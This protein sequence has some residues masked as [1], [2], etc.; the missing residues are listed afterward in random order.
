MRKSI[1]ATRALSFFLTLLVFTTTASSESGYKAWLRYQPVQNKV[2]ADTYRIYC[3]TVFIA[4]ESEILSSSF[5][6][7]K[8]GLK[9]MLGTEPGLSSNGEKSG[10]LIGTIDKIPPS[11]YRF[12]ETETRRMSVEGFIIKNTGK[13]I[14]ITAKSDKGILYGVFRLLMMMQYG[15]ALSDA[16]ILEN[17]KI[18]LR[19]LNH[20]DNP[21]KVPPGT[22][23]VERGYAGGSIFKWDELP[24]L[25]ERYRDYA[26]LLA[27][28]GINGTVINNVN[29]A[30]N[31]LEGWKLLTPEYLPKLKA[32]ADVFRSY[33]IRLY[34]SVNFFSPILIS[35][36]KDADPYNPDVQQWWKNKVTEIYS[37]IPDFGGFL[38][39]ADSEGEPGPI[40]YGRTQA[41]GANLLASALKPHGGLLMWRA[42]V[43]GN[44]ELSSDRACQAFQVFKPLDG[45][46]D[47]NAAVQIKNGP[48]DFQVREPV[49]TLFGA[50]PATSQILELQITQEYTGQDKHVCYLLP[51][52]KEIMGF[53][54]YAE[55]AGST[56]ARLIG[57]DLFDQKN[58]GI[59]GVSNIGDDMNWTGHLLAQAN[60]YAFGRIAW[61]P[62]LETEAI[63]REWIIQTWGNSEKVVQVLEDILLSSWKSYEDYTSPLGVGMMCASDHFNPNPS[64]RTGYHKADKMGIGYDRT[65]LSGSGYTGQYHPSA[66]SVFENLNKCPEELLLFFHHV[67]YSYKLRSGKTVIQNIYD[68]HNEGVERVRKYISEWES[69]SSLI[70]K[71]RYN[72]VLGK[73]RQQVIYAEEWRDSI[74]SYFYNLSG[75]GDS[76][77]SRQGSGR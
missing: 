18:K 45:K 29:T 46:F 57:G 59:A 31:G 62:S 58:S 72:A 12:S 14:I 76:G 22:P 70:D 4:G 1:D 25:N 75:I 23:P 69:L 43:Y 36:L 27:S 28:V 32:L 13:Q 48:I 35:G 55:G 73:L 63:T 77:K 54:T 33:G 66:G 11:I 41:D 24:I 38:V 64:G 39:K 53:D 68:T 56:V 40:K 17:P 15:E 50:M 2:L 26:R 16:D 19:L 8:T 20:W 37:E 51:Q 49:S 34:I 30:K 42:F 9:G 74:N 5:N 7:L 6:E 44:K 67:P 21:G 71:D 60:L 10:L 3:S 61:N 47:E 65:G 52:W